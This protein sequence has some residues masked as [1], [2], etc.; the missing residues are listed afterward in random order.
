MVAQ[1]KDNLLVAEGLKKSFGGVHAVDGV[2]FQVPKG[3]ITGLI[4]PNGA[5]KSTV[6]NSL[7]GFHRI[8][9][10]HVILDGVDITNWPAHKVAQRGLI[11]TFQIARE[12]QRLTVFEN[13]LLAPQGQVGETAW[14]AL[15]RRKKISALEHENLRRA[16]ELLK[17]F[18]LFHVRDEYAGNLSGG[19]KKLLDLARALMAHPRL[20]LLDEPMAG[21]NPTL[22]V[23]LQEHIRDLKNEQGITFLLI[24]H[25]LRIVESLCDHVVVMAEGRILA[26]GSMTTLRENE[27]VVKAYLGG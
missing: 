21:V 1:L 5:G 27:E 6:V 14:Q 18:N 20:V 11:R 2:S 26:E 12:L 10:G 23:E 13:L 24:E 9:K 15:V 7:S 3:T 8:D 25:N 4:G 16:V 22:A 17:R 19:Q